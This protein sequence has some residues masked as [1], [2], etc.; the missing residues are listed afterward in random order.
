MHF[1][2]QLAL[3]WLVFFSRWLFVFFSVRGRVERLVC[4]MVGAIIPAKARFTT[5]NAG[6]RD[7][8]G[9]WDNRFFCVLLVTA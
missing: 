9:V 2:R 4:E 8:M 5:Q 3:S 1:T 7:R 6:F